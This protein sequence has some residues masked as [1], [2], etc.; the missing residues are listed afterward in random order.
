[1]IVS[2]SFLGLVL[3]ADEH[4]L[5]LQ[6]AKIPAVTRIPSNGAL[7]C[8]SSKARLIGTAIWLGFC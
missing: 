7:M 5:G 2:S 3:S 1:M 6:F 8:F 4:S